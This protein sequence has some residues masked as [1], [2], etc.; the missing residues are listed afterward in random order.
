[1]V[2]E[3]AGL[4][5]G[6]QDDTCVIGNRARLRI[7]NPAFLKC[8]KYQIFLKN[9]TNLLLKKKA[10]YILVDVMRFIFIGQR[11]SDIKQV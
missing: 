2:L 1:M 6:E 3:P 5:V 4:V 11:I 7:F 9:K 10:H 8:V